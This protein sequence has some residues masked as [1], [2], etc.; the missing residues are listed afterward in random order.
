M[1]LEVWWCHLLFT[2]LILRSVMTEFP[3]QKLYSLYHDLLILP[4]VYFDCFGKWFSS[5]INKQTNKNPPNISYFKRNQS[6][7]LLCL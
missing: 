3:L 5:P 6:L 2:L 7:L 4:S 1:L